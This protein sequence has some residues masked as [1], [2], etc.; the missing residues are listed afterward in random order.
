M[1]AVSII[2]CEYAR[3]GCCTP[4]G[5]Y[6]AMSRE[7]AAKAGNFRGVCPIIGRLRDFLCVSVDRC[8]RGHRPH[9]VPVFFMSRNDTHGTAYKKSLTVRQLVRSNKN[10]TKLWRN[11]PNGKRNDSHSSEGL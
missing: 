1:G 6:N 10:R 8:A 2:I 9:S 11:K 7:I 3:E 5:V 4:G